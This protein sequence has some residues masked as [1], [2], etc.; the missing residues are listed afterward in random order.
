MHHVRGIEM[1]GVNLIV[2]ALTAKDQ[3]VYDLRLRALGMDQYCYIAVRTPGMAYWKGFIKLTC[4]P[5]WKLAS[6]SYLFIH[7]PYSPN[8]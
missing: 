4:S 6:H 1:V 5:T 7:P 3:D 2:K 8:L